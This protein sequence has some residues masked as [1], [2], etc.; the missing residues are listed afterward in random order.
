V[1]GYYRLLEILRN[2]THEE[3]EDNVAWLKGHV[4][5]YYPFHPDNFSPEKV[6]FEN[7]KRRWKI[8][9]SQDEEGY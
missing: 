2:P 8:A 7:P 6:R 1:P 4:K 9:F 5:N 3:H